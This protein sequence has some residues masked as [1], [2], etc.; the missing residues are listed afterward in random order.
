[1]LFVMQNSTVFTILAI[2]I[3]LVAFTILPT[4]VVASQ[5]SSLSSQ[6]LPLI[7]YS[8]KWRTLLFS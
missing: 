1:M 8:D 3:A 7:L 6:Y 5:S 2:A 4:S